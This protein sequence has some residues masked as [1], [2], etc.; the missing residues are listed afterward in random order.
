MPFNSTGERTFYTNTGVSQGRIVEMTATN[1]VRHVVTAGVYGIGVATED[2]AA[3][4][5]GNIRLW[6][7]GGTFEIAASGTA[8]TT[9]N[10][11]EAIAGG[12]AGATTGTGSLL[13]LNDGV[14]SN[15]II[16]EFIK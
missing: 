7:A 15:G 8:V 2:V 3:A 5:Y 14:A 16:L 9:N 4:A 1:G 12:Y 11:Y 10:T 6:N 13:A